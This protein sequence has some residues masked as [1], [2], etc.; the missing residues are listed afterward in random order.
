[1]ESSRPAR[2]DDTLHLRDGFERLRLVNG[3]RARPRRHHIPLEQILAAVRI[4]VLHRAGEVCVASPVRA[5]RHLVEAC[6]V[7]IGE[8]GRPDKDMLLKAGDVVW[9]PMSWY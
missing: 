8:E 7:E 1:M 5:S 6:L 2:L 9:V 3:E 4:A